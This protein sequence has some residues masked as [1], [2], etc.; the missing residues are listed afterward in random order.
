V[1]PSAGASFF[2][3]ETQRAI[4]ARAAQKQTF[5][6]DLAVFDTPREYSYL[7]YSLGLRGRICF[8]L[9]LSL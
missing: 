1:R 6:S 9:G 8:T 4:I 7:T 2:L 3:N 5:D